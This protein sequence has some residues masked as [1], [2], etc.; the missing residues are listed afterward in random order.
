MNQDVLKKAFDE[1]LKGRKTGEG[2]RGGHITGHTKSG[3]PIYGD[4]KPK[5]LKSVLTKWDKLERQKE[6][7]EEKMED[8]GYNVDRD[9]LRD[10][11]DKWD[12]EQEALVSKVHDLLHAGGLAPNRHSDD[13]SG[14]TIDQID[15]DPRYAKWF[16]DR[17]IPHDYRW[18]FGDGWA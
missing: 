14:V 10:N 6:R 4:K 17:G 16:E 13:F 1:L 3:K 18:I 7:A 11:I 8:G 9:R 15:K 5:S 2:S 12:D